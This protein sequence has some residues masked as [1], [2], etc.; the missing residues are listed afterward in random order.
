MLA[1]QGHQWQCSGTRCERYTIDRGFFLE[2]F[3]N[4][5]SFYDTGFL[6]SSQALGIG[7]RSPRYSNVRH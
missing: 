3:N 4:M 1:G 7:R 2:L 5:L 6:Q